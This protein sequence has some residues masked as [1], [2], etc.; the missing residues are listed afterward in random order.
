M[1]LFRPFAVG[2]NGFK[3]HARL[4]LLYLLR[5]EFRSGQL[6]RCCLGV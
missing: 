1:S 6:Q 4:E 5:W 3:T 2:F